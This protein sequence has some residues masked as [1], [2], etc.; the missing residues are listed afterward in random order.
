MQ[1]VKSFS[2]FSFSIG[3]VKRNP[4]IPNETVP[5]QSEIF[6]YIFK[7]LSL[8]EGMVQAELIFN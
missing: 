2:K 7:Q 5:I 1:S 3:P 6:L 8:E 4:R